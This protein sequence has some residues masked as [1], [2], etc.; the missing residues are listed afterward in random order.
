MR[1]CEVTY[2]YNPLNLDELK[3]EVGEI[4]EIIREVKASSLHVSL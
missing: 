1:Q 2:S 3:L 4:V